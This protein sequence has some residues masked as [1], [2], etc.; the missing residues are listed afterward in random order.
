MSRLLTDEEIT[1]A[2]A[3]HIGT[4]LKTHPQ[5]RAIAEAQAKLTRAETL[6]EVEDALEVCSD[7]TLLVGEDDKP[8]K[9]Y[10]FDEYQL[11]KMMAT[12]KGEIPE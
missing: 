1:E 4:P 3:P 7:D 11:N 9:F 8:I 2:R 6:K 12:L 5:H 10:S